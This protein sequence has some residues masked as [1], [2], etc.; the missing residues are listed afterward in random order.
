MRSPLFLRFQIARSALAWLCV[1]GVAS[2]AQ[3]GS[4]QFSDSIFQDSDWTGSE[5]LDTTGNNS[6]V[7]TGAQ[8]LTGG[9]P[10]EYR[11]VTHSLNTPVGVGVNVASAHVFGGGSF[12]PGQDG[13][14]VSLDFSWEGISINSSAGAVG[15]GALVFQDG[16]AYVHGAGQTLNGVGWEAY[17]LTGLTGIDFFNLNDSS[18]P[19]FSNAGSPLQFGF[20]ASN[21]TFGNSF[22]DGGVDNWSVV[23][24]FV[25]EPSTASLLSLGL[26]ATALHRRAGRTRPRSGAC[27]P[28]DSIMRS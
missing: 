16:L 2:A 9:N 7:F 18:V 28:E 22:N 14:I 8:R 26:L 21:G 5:I 6:F 17:S 27:V 10:D 15:Y 19:D 4:V 23:V 1:L 25:P 20:F 13:T 24:N 12:D 11:R 3:A